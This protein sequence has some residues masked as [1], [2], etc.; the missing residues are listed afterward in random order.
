MYFVYVMYAMDALTTLST[1]ACRVRPPALRQEPLTSTMCL[2]TL[3]HASVCA[4]DDRLFLWRRRS[5][6]G[7]LLVDSP[8]VA[9]VHGR[10]CGASYVGRA[11]RHTSDL[12]EIRTLQRAVPRRA[13][14]HGAALQEWVAA[15]QHE[16]PVGAGPAARH[17]A[18]QRR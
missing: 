11:A 8:R 3:A 4:R 15:P 10:G 9:H 12:L 18:R 13:R 6:A 16:A 7:L 1:C 14:R 5:R 17:H 2:A